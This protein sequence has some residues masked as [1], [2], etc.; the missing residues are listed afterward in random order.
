MDESVTQFQRF[1]VGCL[2]ALEI[3]LIA[4][5]VFKFCLEDLALMGGGQ[6]IIRWSF[7]QLVGYLQGLLGLVAPV[8]NWTEY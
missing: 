4:R 3:V 8:I 5:N 7:D 1:H 6:E 2:L